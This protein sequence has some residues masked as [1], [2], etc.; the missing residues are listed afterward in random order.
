MWL[1]EESFR[2]KQKQVVSE[3]IKLPKVVREAEKMELG[4]YPCEVDDR[5]HDDDRD[6]DSPH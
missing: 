2:E 4:E 6:R 1:Q 3:G 5:D